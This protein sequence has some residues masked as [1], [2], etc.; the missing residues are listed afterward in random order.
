M[1][2]LIPEYELAKSVTYRCSRARLAADHLKP[3]SKAKKK[4]R[5]RLHNADE[6]MKSGIRKQYSRETN[7]RLHDAFTLQ[8]SRYLYSRISQDRLRT[9]TRHSHNPDS[10]TDKYESSLLRGP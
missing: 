4:L 3:D 1:V 7:F 8:K 5:R 9:R 2:V 10:S 6:Q